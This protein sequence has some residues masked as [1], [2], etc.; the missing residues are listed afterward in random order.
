MLQVP[1]I[2]FKNSR[3]ILFKYLWNMQ[4]VLIC[5]STTQIFFQRH[6]EKCLIRKNTRHW[7]MGTCGK[8]RYILLII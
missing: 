6:T 1:L 3:I 7:L 2:S 4:L 8:T 5:T